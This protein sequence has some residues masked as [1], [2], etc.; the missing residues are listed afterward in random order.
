MTRPRPVPVPR[1]SHASLWAAAEPILR[2]DRY[3]RRSLGRIQ[4]EEVDWA[5]VRYLVLQ[6]PYHGSRNT[7][8]LYGALSRAYPDLTAECQRQARP[9]VQHRPF[10]CDYPERL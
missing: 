2:R 10:S 8:H 3:H 5:M 9:G 1:L 7:E 4:P 6:I